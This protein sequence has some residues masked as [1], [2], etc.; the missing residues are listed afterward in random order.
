MGETIR[1]WSNARLA[2][3]SYTRVHIE[4]H[5]QKAA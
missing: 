3:L 2:S 5:P 4:A 1:E